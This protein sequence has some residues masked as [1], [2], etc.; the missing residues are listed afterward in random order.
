MTSHPKEPN[1][2]ESLE[3]IRAALAVFPKGWATVFHEVREREPGVVEIG[4]L[5]EDS[6]D[7]A[8]VIT[9]DTGNYY[10]DAAAMPMAKFIAACNPEAIAT[11]LDALKARDA[12]I[13]R[14]RGDAERYQF[15]RGRNG[16]FTVERYTNGW[17]TCFGPK[18]LDAAIDQAR[19]TGGEKA[20]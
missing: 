15:L 12:E 2:P 1:L 9:V 16:D 8:E 14:L 19:A 4:A 3:A 5:W 20:K 7:L 17:A 6:D 10:A 11:L 13:E 18:E